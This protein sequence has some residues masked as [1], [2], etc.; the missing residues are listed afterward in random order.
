MLLFSLTYDK[1]SENIHKYA[2]YFINICISSYLL[3]C[4]THLTTWQ[5]AD[6][7]QMIGT[8]FAK[9]GV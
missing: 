2:T 1:V 6:G 9:D 8:D 7:C 4:M 3:L 5:M